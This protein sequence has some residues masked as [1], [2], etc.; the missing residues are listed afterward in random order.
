MRRLVLSSANLCDSSVGCH[1]HNGGLVAFQ[2]SIQEGEAL[3]VQHVNFVDE[4]NTGHNLSPALF[5]PLSHFL[6]DLLSHFGLNFSNVTGEESH[7]TLGAR[8]NHIDFVQG[9]SVHHLLSLLKFAFG[10]LNKAGLRAH[11]VIVR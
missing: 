8:V 11:I 10:T 5:S 7:E 2:R 4:K 3:D 1:D 9:N 6:V